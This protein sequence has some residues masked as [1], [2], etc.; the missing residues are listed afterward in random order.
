MSHVEP[1]MVREEVPLKNPKFRDVEE[2]EVEEGEAMTP[3]LCA[4]DKPAASSRMK[5]PV[6]QRA[7]KTSSS[8]SSSLPS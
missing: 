4:R 6:R 1:A 5:E 3:L 8:T 2:E 7:S